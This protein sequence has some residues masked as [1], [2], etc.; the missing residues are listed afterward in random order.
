MPFTNKDYPQTTEARFL[1][2]FADEM[3]RTLC[4]VQRRKGCTISAASNRLLIAAEIII[5]VC[6]VVTRKG[7]VLA[8]PVPLGNKHLLLLL[9]LAW[10]TLSEWSS[11]KWWWRA[12]FD[13]LSTHVR[14]TISSAFLFEVLPACP[15]RP[16]TSRASSRVIS[17][18]VEQSLHTEGRAAV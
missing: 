15:P 11:F 12:G 3:E 13:D 1:D 8:S 16:A 4:H 9:L 14:K 2:S 7:V 5:L 17:L 6:A 10:D 18:Q